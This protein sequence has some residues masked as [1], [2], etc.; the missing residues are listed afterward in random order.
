[1]K[2]VS[3]AISFCIL[4]ATCLLVTSTCRAAEARERKLIE[5]VVSGNAATVT[6]TAQTVSFVPL[7]DLYPFRIGT[8]L[9]AHQVA[10]PSPKVEQVI[11]GTFNTVT[12]ENELKPQ[13]VQPREGVWQFAAGDRFVSF[14]ERHQM[15]PIGHCLVWHSQTG[16]WM[17]KDRMGQPASR[18][19]VVARMRT[20]IRT[21]VGRYRGRIKGWDVVN[22]AFG[23]DGRLHPSPWL[24]CVG[25]DFVELA[26]RFAHEADPACE[27][28]YN[29]FGLDNPRKR[30]GVV[31]MIRDFKKKG[32]RIDGIGMQSHHHLRTP[33]LREYEAS[34][35]AFAAEGVKVMITELDI[36]VL[37]SA[38]GHTAE[39]SASH[40][41]RSRFDPYRNGLPDACQREL[42]ARYV[43]LFTIYLRH[44]NSIDRVTFW[45]FTDAASW[46]NN[47]PV[48]GRKD[49][50]LL[51]DRDLKPKPCA[52]AL[53]NLV[54]AA[55]VHS[56]HPQKE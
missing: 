11:A 10:Q 38:W 20:H 2:K 33:D 51:Y 55:G 30:A 7:K 24:N 4:T 42:T 52:Q 8:C 48:R 49:Y 32:I 6:E 29:D 41:Y 27:L 9:N 23:G 40:A 47:F 26:F 15:K 39:I 45:G 56:C 21:V 37:P 35:A 16:D 17:F 18:E 1:M 43:A 13:S 46:L 50:P 53:A 22:E 28:Y 3:F 14:A 54:Q 19:V 5:G 31:K 34:I 44:A 25:P 12:P 36:S